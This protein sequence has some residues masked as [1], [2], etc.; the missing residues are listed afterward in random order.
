[1]DTNYNPSSTKT[2][3]DIYTY[4]VKQSD[5]VYLATWTYSNPDHYQLATLIDI[6]KIMKKSSRIYRAWRSKC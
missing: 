3:R 2:T 1:M 5:N 4:T 6:A